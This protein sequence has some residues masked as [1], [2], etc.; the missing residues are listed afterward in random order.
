MKGECEHN[1]R[2]LHCQTLLS[3]YCATCQCVTRQTHQL[4]TALENVSN[5]HDNIPSSTDAAKYLK[6]P[7]KGTE[8]ESCSLVSNQED[9]SGFADKN[10]GYTNG[11]TEKDQLDSACSVEPARTP[12]SSCLPSHNDGAQSSLCSASCAEDVARTN[13]DPMGNKSS[14]GEE[15]SRHKTAADS[16]LHSKKSRSS[17]QG[18]QRLAQLQNEKRCK[19]KISYRKC[20]LKNLSSRQTTKQ[21]S[22]SDSPQS[23]PK[24]ADLNGRYVCTVC[25]AS[26]G[27]LNRLRTH[28]RRAHTCERPYPCKL[29]CAAFAEQFDLK[30]HINNQHIGSRPCACDV[31]GKAYFDNNTLKRHIM[32][33]HTQERPH[34]CQICQTAF[35]ERSELS[36]HIQHFHEDSGAQQ[37]REKTNPPKPY[38][39]SQCGAHFGHKSSLESHMHRHTGLKPFSCSFCGNSFRAKSTLRCH[40][41]IHMDDRRFVC[42]L[43]GEK[44]I[45][46]SALT[47]HRRKHSGEKPYVCEGCAKGFYISGDLKKHRN[48]CVKLKINK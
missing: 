21:D 5:S 8:S 15:K 10:L 28:Y 37:G 2:C 25:D 18:K 39:C 7:Q 4:R 33:S 12:V 40:M 26:L 13:R 27:C 38:L 44:Y 32:R 29:C 34:V 43:C 16:D 17:R 22:L 11:L 41:R 23:L 1:V 42:E 30:R 6:H 35:L 31:C 24:S 36:K 20:G 45:T 47:V 19:F 46:K 14:Q 3:L 9:A 48:S